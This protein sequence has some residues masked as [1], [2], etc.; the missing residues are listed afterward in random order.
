MKMNGMMHAGVFLSFLSVSILFV[1]LAGYGIDYW[2]TKRL[3]ENK[4]YVGLN[5]RGTL[6]AGDDGH[7][8]IDVPGGTWKFVPKKGV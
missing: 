1:G 6:I 7:T 3:K 8:T 5:L 4:S 2:L